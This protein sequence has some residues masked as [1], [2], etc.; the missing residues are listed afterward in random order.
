M[1]DKV[2]VEIDAAGVRHV[3]EYVDTITGLPITD[4]EWR[5]YN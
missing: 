5:D 2:R 4:E 3:V 1:P